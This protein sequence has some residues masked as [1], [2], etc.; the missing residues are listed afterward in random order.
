[1]L[2]SLCLVQGETESRSAVSTGRVFFLSSISNLGLSIFNHF[3]I[4]R[5]CIAC[6]KKFS[7]QHDVT[8]SKRTNEIAKDTKHISRQM[9]ELISYEFSLKV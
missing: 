9:H 5:S 7:L 6:L 8:C 1:M 4:H 2:T 3:Y